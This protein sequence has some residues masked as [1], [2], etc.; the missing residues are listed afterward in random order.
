D[1]D[2]H[3]WVDEAE[4]DKL[5]RRGGRWLAAHP[6]KELI[7]R[8]YLR[9]NRRLSDAAL[10]RLLEEDVVSDPDEEAESRDAEEQAVEKPIG[11]NIQRLDAVVS[12]V[13]G[14]GSRR[15]ADLGCGA[16][17]LLGRLLKDTDIERLLGLDVSHRSL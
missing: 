15:V 7:T 12:E 4:I 2:K 17:N 13:R 1:D 3:Y 6:D 11:L 16:G 8:R 5:L 9:Y 14:A 10:A